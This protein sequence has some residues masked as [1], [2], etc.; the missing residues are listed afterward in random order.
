M[1]LLGRQAPAHA[2]LALV[3]GSGM[4]LSSRLA[5]LRRV[6]AG[7]HDWYAGVR[8]GAG[9]SVL[10]EHLRE[11]GFGGV[12]RLI[13]HL[14]LSGDVTGTSLPSTADEGRMLARPA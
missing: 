12:A 4:R 9:L 14:P 6:L 7:L 13:M 3:E 2:M 10:L 5:S 11:H 1:L 8:D